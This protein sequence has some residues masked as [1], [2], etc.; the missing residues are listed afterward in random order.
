MY[1]YILWFSLCEQIWIWVKCHHY[2]LVKVKVLY[3]VNR[4]GANSHVFTKDPS[5]PIISLVLAWVGS[6][7]FLHAHNS[8]WHETQTDQ[9]KLNNVWYNDSNLVKLRLCKVLAVKETP[10][11]IAN[12]AMAES[13]IKIICAKNTI[14]LKITL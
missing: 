6:H 2:L 11:S 13:N 14:P 7:T 12:I 5:L 9:T 4:G 1:R 3:L 8:L 10:L